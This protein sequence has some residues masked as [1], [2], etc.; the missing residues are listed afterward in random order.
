MLLKNPQM[1]WGLLVLAIPLLIHLLR[2]RRFRKTPFT[3]VRI[4]QQLVVESNRSSQLKKWLLLLARLGL[5]A[6]LVIAFAQPYSARED[7]GKPRSIA[8][9]L[10]NSF[11]MQA[12]EG[13]TNLLQ[14]AVQTLL[15]ELPPNF[16]CALL[17][18]TDQYSVRPLSELQE[19]LLGM[20][21][22]H[23]KADA[24]SLLL[25]AGAL[26]PA[27]SETIR[28]IWLIS[29]FQDFDF[30]QADTTGLPEIHALALR[31][32]QRA[33]MSLDTAFINS[34]NPEILE[35]QVGISLDD[36][37]RIKPLSLF[38][39]DTLIAKS[40]PEL[41]GARRGQAIFSLPAGEAIEGAIRILDEGL[42]YD[43]NL[44]FSLTAP[45]RIRVYSLGPGPTDYL[46]R[47]YT[48]DEFDFESSGLR[49]LDFALLET[50]H[51]LILNE[52]PDIPESLGRSLQDFLKT[53][54]TLLVIPS[55][56][57]QVD[58]YNRWLLEPAGLPLGTPVAQPARITGVAF[59][60]PL[61][62]DVFEGR[63][64][65]FEY[66]SANGH[67]ALGA[68]GVSA[69]LSFQNG[70][71]FLAVRDKT[72]LFTAALNPNN[73]NF[74]QSPLIVPTLYAMARQSLPFPELYYTIGAPAALDLDIPLAGEQVFG[75]H[76]PEYDFIPYQQGFARKTRMEFGPEP[77]RDGNYAILQGE[78]RVGM[79]S[80]NFPRTESSPVYPA[81][82]FP[83]WVTRHSNLESVIESYQNET[84]I[85]SLWKWFVIL[86]LLFAAAELILQK[87]M[88]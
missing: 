32:D 25:R 39:R 15:Q 69:P 5:L 72:Y 65:N 1:L 67:Y 6:A 11:S 28:E 80:F 27:D 33:N 83:E 12:P 30:S 23:V 13:S 54:G 81:T 4:L 88:R 71:P 86:A 58:T 36:T 35:L 50:Q 74:R 48:S 77:D 61:F 78:R 16:R 10:D 66:P 47:I 79:V 21:F 75:L 17:T 3:N 60:H 84:E 29:D 8:L 18:N 62:R 9:Y 41:T 37:T 14:G 73:G 87:T 42:G 7:A 49:E 68:A 40:A 51:L 55:T 76:S 57:A 82:E 24:P 53:G 22:T 31:P 45:P 2:L 64:T 59:D 85:R 20:P 70:D 46:E 34:R 19:T 38:N 26:L 63:V 56:E 44:Y 52:L 43:N